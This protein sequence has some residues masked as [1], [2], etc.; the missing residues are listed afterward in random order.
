MWAT[1]A[2]VHERFVEETFGSNDFRVYDEWDNGE[3]MT[4]A[5]VEL[6]ERGVVVRTE[7]FV[8]A[9]RICCGRSLSW[10]GRR[11]RWGRSCGCCG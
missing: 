7:T 8:A 3:F 1:E 4:G 11:R 10:S 9:S 6:I 5:K 2:E